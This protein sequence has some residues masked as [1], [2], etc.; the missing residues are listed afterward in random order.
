LKKREETEMN[1]KILDIT[2]KML[3][4][5]EV[6]DAEVELLK[7][8]NL[9]YALVKFIYMEKR[10]HDALEGSTK[11]M[12]FFFSPGS[13]FM[14]TPIYDIVENL[15]KFDISVKNL[16]GADISEFDYQSKP[17]FTGMEKRQL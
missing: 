15:L 2:R 3:V 12:N 10:K 13:E 4:G 17:P 7:E 16:I 9:K 8:Y 11:L 5:E 6:S 14:E 1:D